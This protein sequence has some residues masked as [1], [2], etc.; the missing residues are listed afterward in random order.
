MLQ[1]LHHTSRFEQIVSHHRKYRIRSTSANSSGWC[2]VS[3]FRG[4]KIMRMHGLS[5]HRTT[6]PIGLPVQWDCSLVIQ[7]LK[8]SGWNLPV[9][10][11]AFHVVNH[12][13]WFTITDMQS[14]AA[15]FS[16]H[17]QMNTRISRAQRNSSMKSTSKNHLLSAFIQIA[18]SSKLEVLIKCSPAHLRKSPSFICIRSFDRVRGVLNPKFDLHASYLSPVAADRRNGLIVRHVDREIMREWR[19]DF[20]L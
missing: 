12:N 3:T 8:S 19:L 14:I 5:L 4:L 16:H 9:D 18:L 17:L 6:F 11:R 7:S 10:A 20:R 2:A 13:L 15:A 1:D